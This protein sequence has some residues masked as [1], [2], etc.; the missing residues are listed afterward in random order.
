MNSRILYLKIST[1]PGN[2]KNM[3]SSAR[4]NLHSSFSTPPHPYS[5][6]FTV[7]PE[8][9]T[10]SLINQALGDFVGRRKDIGV[11][12][13]QNRAAVIEKINPSCYPRKSQKNQIGSS[14]FC[15]GHANR[16]EVRAFAVKI[17]ETVLDNACGQ[18]LGDRAFRA[19][20][21]ATSSAHWVVMEFLRFGNQIPA[22]QGNPFD[23]Q[24]YCPTR[25][26]CVA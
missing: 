7:W 19:T 2:L 10:A 25:T 15:I 8:V 6:A 18:T 12:I 3:P 21:N 26:C 11:I 17:T 24:E 23:S 1:L 5:S 14:A 20:R 22:L 9:E 13:Y 4:E 16:I